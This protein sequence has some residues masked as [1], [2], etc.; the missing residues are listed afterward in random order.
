MAEK[1]LISTDGTVVK[2]KNGFSLVDFNNLSS[3]PSTPGNYIWLL[4]DA[5]N[6]PQ[7]CAEVFPVYNYID[8]EKIR[9]R[10]LY[11]GK[12]DSNLYKR[13][14]N[15]LN[16]KIATSTLRKS[17]AA[18]CGF[19]QEVYFSGKTKKV[20]ISDVDEKYVSNWLRSNCLLL[21]RGCGSM[22][23]ARELESNL[24]NQL[25]PPLNIDDNP[26][27]HNGEFVEMLSALRSKNN[28][29]NSGRHTG[30]YT[31]APK[32]ESVYERLFVGKAFK[33]TIFEEN[34]SIIWACAIVLLVLM[35][36]LLPHLCS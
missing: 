26:R 25:D 2:L 14:R 3:I 13:L 1:D 12:S 9:Y 5:C 18:L 31:M 11:T 35:S 6:L 30:V 28:T 16:G 34:K 23:E 36:L 7:S 32:K 20:R 10:V 22:K 29:Y 4:K 27:K 8:Y 19:R 33:G 15:H 24:I 21:V 17:I